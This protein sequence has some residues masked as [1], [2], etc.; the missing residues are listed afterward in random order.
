[1]FKK[2]SDPISKPYSGSRLL[3]A[4]LLLP[5]AYESKHTSFTSS[6]RAWPPKFI[7]KQLPIASA[8][9]EERRG[10]N[11]SSKEQGPKNNRK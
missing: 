11:T 6:N 10:K 4:L 9:V 2:S 7:L 3:N 8:V 5:V 1:M